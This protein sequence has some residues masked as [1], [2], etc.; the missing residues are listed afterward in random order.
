MIKKIGLQQILQ[1]K[2]QQQINQVV[3]DTQKTK[4][5]QNLMFTYKKLKNVY[6]KMEKKYLKN[7][8][9]VTQN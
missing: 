5:N 3:E 9:N 6:P 7:G 2:Y 8:K 4:K 1:R